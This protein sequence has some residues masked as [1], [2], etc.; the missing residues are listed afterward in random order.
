MPNLS[1]YGN[2]FHNFFCVCCDI[3]E[4]KVPIISYILYICSDTS[5]INQQVCL[6]WVRYHHRDRN[7]SFCIRTKLINDYHQIN[8]NVC[9][10]SPSVLQSTTN[11]WCSG[12]QQLG[13]HIWEMVAPLVAIDSVR[14]SLPDVDGIFDTSFQFWVFDW[15]FHTFPINGV[16]T[17]CHMVCPCRLVVF[18]L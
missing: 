11:W 7:S 4:K 9:Q 3:S 5:E 16:V 18:C 8:F 2:I 6:C 14:P 1:N 12:L 15:Q 17:H 10:T 13:I